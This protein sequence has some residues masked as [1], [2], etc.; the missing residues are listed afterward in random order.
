[1]V[2]NFSFVCTKKTCCQKFSF[3]FI[4]FFAK[5]Q[6]KIS[7]SFHLVLKAN[8]G[9]QDVEERVKESLRNLQTNYIDL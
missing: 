6:Q 8:Q 9:E 7:F 2:L 5:A 1:M 3:P 4:E